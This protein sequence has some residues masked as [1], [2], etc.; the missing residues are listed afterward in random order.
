MARAPSAMPMPSGVRDMARSFCATTPLRVGADPRDA[1]A[2]A[3][4]LEVAMH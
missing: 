2:A 1:T 4:R 3:R